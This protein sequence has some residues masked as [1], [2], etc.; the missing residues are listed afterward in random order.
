[1]Q[2]LCLILPSFG[3]YSSRVSCPISEAPN[4]QFNVKRTHNF[5]RGLAAFSIDGRGKENDHSFSSEGRFVRN[6]RL[7]TDNTEKAERTKHIQDS[8]S[9]QAN[10][11]TTNALGLKGITPKYAMAGYK[12]DSGIPSRVG[13]RI[14]TGLKESVGLL[15]LTPENLLETYINTIRYNPRL[16]VVEQTGG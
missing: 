7:F 4:P 13:S 16:N 6:Q 11:P 14:S 10:I 5:S 9:R 12:I 3:L 8:A 1:M 15:G 2:R